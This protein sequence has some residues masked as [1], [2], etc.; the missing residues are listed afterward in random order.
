MTPFPKNFFWG[1]STSAHQIEGH[2]TNDWSQWEQSERRAEELKKKGKNPSD[3]IAGSACDSWEHAETDLACL[4]QLGV[5]AYRFSIEWSRVEPRRGEFNEEVIE[6]YRASIMTLRQNGIEPFVTLWHFTVPLWVRD[7][8]GWESAQTIEDFAAFTKRI[9]E[10]LGE[11]VRFW[12][13][14]NEPIV[15]AVQSYLIGVW[16]PQQKS[17]FKTIRVAHNLM[18]AHKR[19]YEVIKARNPELQI[20]LSNHSIHFSAKQPLLFNQ[21]IARVGTYFWN[22]W[23]L[24]RARNHQDFIGINYYFHKSV[25]FQFGKK[26]QIVSDLNWELYPEGL[27]RVLLSLK[28]F[29][30]P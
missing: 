25:D 4:N 10:A 24:N 19:A 30:K 7:Q 6:R 14:V 20:G 11:D 18:R 9:V 16:P 2:V 29:H 22:E 1:C 8:G 23:F 15:Y 28:R 3:F 12:I 21:L 13:T 17:F 26:D 27:G 5:N